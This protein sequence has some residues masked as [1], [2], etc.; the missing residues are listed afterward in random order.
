VKKFGSYLVQHYLLLYSA[1]LY[2]EI[3][4][5]LVKVERG[6]SHCGQGFRSQHEL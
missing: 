3:F 2:F 6:F 5:V 1:I 4:V